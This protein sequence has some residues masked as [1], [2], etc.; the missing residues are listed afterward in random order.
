M[1]HFRPK[2]DMADSARPDEPE[3]QKFSEAELAELQ[4]AFNLF[5]LDGGGD[6]DAK[7]LGT[8]MRRRRQPFHAEVDQMIAEVDDDDSG[9]IEFPEFVQLMA[10]KLQITDCPAELKEAWHA[11]DDASQGYIW[12]SQLRTI[13]AALSPQLSEEEVYEICH[14]ASDDAGRVTFDT[15]VALMAGPSSNRW[16]GSPGHK[17]FKKKEQEAIAEEEPAE[18]TAAEAP[19]SS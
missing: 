13:I 8:V 2:T 16:P 9:C 3:L 14:L 11:F 4:E 19:C 18:Q 5:D 6:I 10:R 12:K 7:E 17:T 15:F 1:L